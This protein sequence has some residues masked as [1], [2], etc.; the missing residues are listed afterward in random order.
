LSKVTYISFITDKLNI[1]IV[2]P[3]DIISEFCSK[4]HKTERTF[5]N[6]W[7]E[8]KSKWETL[9]LTKEKDKADAIH[10]N[11]LN[12]L[13]SG[14][15]SKEER[16]LSLQKQIDDIEKI[17]DDGITPDAIFDNK[18]MISVDVERKL[19]AIERANLMKVHREL[20]AELNKMDGSYA[21]TKQEVS[22]TGPIRIVRE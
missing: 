16:Q 1:G 5:W 19:T 9:Q 7:K 10:Q 17:L 6:Q 13:K 11:D 4:F 18:A 15:K 2:D 8:A 22:Q 20:I 3:K 12:T 21:V 14:L